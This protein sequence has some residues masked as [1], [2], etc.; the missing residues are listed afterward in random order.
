MIT[1]TRFF[2]QHQGKA[3][4]FSDA[5]EPICVGSDLHRAVQEFDLCKAH[6]RLVAIPCHF[7]TDEPTAKGVELIRV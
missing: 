4:D 1:T 3:A 7:M 2:V 6:R 5:R